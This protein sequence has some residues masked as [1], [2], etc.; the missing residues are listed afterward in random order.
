M[1]SEAVHSSV[2]LNSEP[3]HLP[4]EAEEWADTAGRWAAWK[5]LSRPAA[6]GEAVHSLTLTVKGL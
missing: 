1:F 6:E 2:G 3:A 4:K 5:E